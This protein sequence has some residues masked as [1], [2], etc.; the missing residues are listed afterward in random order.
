[1]DFICKLFAIGILSLSLSACFSA[2]GESASIFG[3]N[4]IFTAP[5]KFVMDAGESAKFSL[6]NVD[7]DLFKVEKIS[8]SS[9]GTASCRIDVSFV[10]STEREVTLSS[11]SGQGP[12]TVNYGKLKA[13]EI[14]INNDASVAYQTPFGIDIVGDNAYI[15]DSGS[16]SLIRQNLK[17]GVKTSLVSA[18]LGNAVD[19]AVDKTETYAYVVD[20]SG[21]A[22]IRVDL[23]TY[24]LTT[25]SNT[26]TPNLSYPTRVVVSEDSSFVYV[27]DRS[28]NGVVEIDLSDFSKRIVTD[29]SNTSTIPLDIP[30]SLL[31]D[32][33][34]TYLYVAD[35]D[36]QALFKINIATGDREIL[37][38]NTV[39]TGPTFNKAHSLSFISSNEMAYVDINSDLVMKIN[40]DTGDR[41]IISNNSM[42]DSGPSF[43]TLFSSAKYGE[44]LIVSDSGLDALL[45]VNLKT[46]FRTI[47]G[48]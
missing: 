4:E 1:M 32:S 30:Y 13:Y 21:D 10:S 17:T 15:A 6:K 20:S 16:D 26:G 22:V 25:I 14:L 24:A 5:D 31:V 8:Q 40:I 33:T 18:G 39:G 34:R 23:S 28:L 47:I 12:V 7:P 35:R 3:G 44:Y 27:A 19:V 29:S 11:C 36:Q 9:T 37:S 46:G 38:S 41:S 43:Q 42:A 2:V 45:K 48:K